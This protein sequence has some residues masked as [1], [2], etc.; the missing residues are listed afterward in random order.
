MLSYYIP[1][2]GYSFFKKTCKRLMKRHTPYLNGRP[3]SVVMLLAWKL[4]K[5]SRAGSSFK[6]NASFSAFICSSIN[7]VAT[8]E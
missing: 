3:R 5:T 4:R 2:N 8:L 7:C 1:S 6:L